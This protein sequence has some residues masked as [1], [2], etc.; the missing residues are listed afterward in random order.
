MSVDQAKP[1]RGRGRLVGDSFRCRGFRHKD[2]S[3]ATEGGLHGGIALPDFI[4]LRVRRAICR[5]VAAT[6]LAVLAVAAP[7]FASCPDQPV[8][9]PF[10]QWGDSSNYFLVPGGSLEGSTD[11]VGWTLSNASLAQGNEPFR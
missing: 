9:N 4:H 11:D 6:C 7:A 2:F 5:V 1:P 10:S 8:S 3:C